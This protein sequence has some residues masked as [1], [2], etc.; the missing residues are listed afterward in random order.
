MPF[1]SHAERAFIT[2]CVVNGCLAAALG[3]LLAGLAG[4]Q[5]GLIGGLLLTLLPLSARKAWAWLG[6][7]AGLPRFLIAQAGASAVAVAQTIATVVASVLRPLVSLLQGPKLVAR[8]IIDSVT[9]A[10]ADLLGRLWR[11]LAT[12]LGMANV[13]A[14]GVIAANIAN[15]DFAGPVTFLGF[16]ILLLVLLVSQSEARDEETAGKLGSER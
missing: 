13:A 12:P 8:S 15:L 4:A 2:S 16:G 11:L 14:L 5:S 3:G 10:L 1:I 7:P 6:R 9:R